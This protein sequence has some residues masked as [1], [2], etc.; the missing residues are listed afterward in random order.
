MRKEGD[1]STKTTN[2]QKRTMAKSQ[3]AGG[4]YFAVTTSF[5]RDR[6]VFVE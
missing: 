3:S 4:K 1:T 2:K 5:L 6:Q